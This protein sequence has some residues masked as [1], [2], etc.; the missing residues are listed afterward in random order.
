MVD[1][2][3]DERV[4]VL[5]FSVHL[6]LRFDDSRGGV[7]REEAGVVPVRDTVRDAAVLCAVRVNSRHL[8]NQGVNTLSLNP[9]SMYSFQIHVLQMNMHLNVWLHVPST[10]PFFVPF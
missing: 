5:H 2:V 6:H 4:F 7:D 3:Y 1:G 9:A 8:R 10:S